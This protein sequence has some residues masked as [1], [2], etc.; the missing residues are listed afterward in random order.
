MKPTFNKLEL[1][2]ATEI[3][4]I[5]LSKAADS[6]SFFTKEKVLIRGGSIIFSSVDDGNLFE[7][8]GDNFVALSTQ[9]RGEM[10]GYC[11]LIF[12]E[13]EVDKLA[14]IS[15]PE[16]VIGNPEQYPE[17]RKA[18]LLEADN[19]ITA[20]V[21]TQFSNLLGKNMHGYVPFHHQGGKK[22]IEDYI[23]GNTKENNF[24]LHFKAHLVS[25]G[26]DIVPEFI[27]SLDQTFVESIKTFI[28][29]EDNLV[30]LESMM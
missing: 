21:V 18:I 10:E 4:N 11:Y 22:E 3:V 28:S 25:D 29:N 23:K 19:I 5:G 15:L 12:N 8:E 24:I 14:K 7:K 26:N 17:M 20:A 13:T 27:W 1:D 16:S 9:L 30:K 6:L 2:I